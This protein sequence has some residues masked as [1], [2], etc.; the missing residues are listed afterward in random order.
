[1]KCLTTEREELD[2]RH[3]LKKTNKYYVKDLYNTFVWTLLAEMTDLKQLLFIVR[4]PIN[5]PI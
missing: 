1:M 3:F 4:L 5:K 2:H